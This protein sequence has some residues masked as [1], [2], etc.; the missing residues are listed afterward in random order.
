WGWRR[1]RRRGGRTGVEAG[2][3]PRRPPAAA[4]WTRA[5]ITLRWVT[6]LLRSSNM[7]LKRARKGGP[8]HEPAAACKREEARRRSTAGKKPDGAPGGVYRR[9][10]DGGR[11][12]GPGGVH[13]SHPH[14][15]ARLDC[16]L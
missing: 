7:I 3:A 15:R 9:G 10:R 16:H 2:R 6:T 12:R 4:G 5:E 8:G 13:L 1:A 14:P 11:R